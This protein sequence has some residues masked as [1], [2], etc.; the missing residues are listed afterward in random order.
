MIAVARAGYGDLRCEVAPPVEL[1]VAGVQTPETERL[2]VT[3]HGPDR[4]MD[5][6]QRLEAAQAKAAGLVLVENGLDAGAG[7]Y[8]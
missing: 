4:R 7:S 5:G 2:E 1:Q 6:A 8:P 3:T